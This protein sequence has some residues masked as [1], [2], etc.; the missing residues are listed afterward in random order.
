MPI[1]CYSPLGRYVQPFHPVL[2]S[3]THS[4]GFITRK[5]KSPEDIPEGSFQRMVPRFQGQAFYDNLKLVDELDRLAKEK[6]LETSQLALAWVV[7][8]SPYVSIS[9]LR[10]IQ[11]ND[12]DSVQNIP[13]PGSSN[14]TR[15]KQNTE[16]ANVKLTDDDLKVINEILGK[17]EVTGD[18]YPGPA[19]AQLASLLLLLITELSLTPHRCSDASTQQPRRTD[20]SWRSEGPPWPQFFDKLSLKLVMMISMITPT[21]PGPWLTT[22]V[23]TSVTNGPEHVGASRALGVSVTGLLILPT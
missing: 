17:F 22:R 5:W 13:I 4:R 1:L 14:A 10:S 18:R 15:V 2:P 8:L 7:S 20:V 23:E 19:M 11:G 16:A 6:G 21:R 12:V 3:L 9:S